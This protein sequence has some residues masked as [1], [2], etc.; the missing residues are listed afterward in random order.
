MELLARFGTIEQKEMW[1]GPLLRGEIRSCFG[2]T[3]PA[4]GS[5]DATNVCTAITKSSTSYIINGRKWWTSGASDPH[6][7]LIV[8]LGR[9]P[10]MSSRHNSHTILLVPMDAD[11]VKV[12]RNLKVFGYDDAPHGHAEISFT[13][14]TVPHSSLLYKEGKGFFCAQS[15][16]GGGRLHHCMRAIGA[17][18]RALAL[19]LSQAKTRVLGGTPLIKKDMFL[20]NI[21]QSRCDISAARAL[22]LA[23]CN[24]VDNNEKDKIREAVAIAKI[25]VPNLVHKVLDRAIQAHGG[26]G[27]S[28]DTVLAQLYAHMRS[29]RLADGPDEVH[30]LNLGKMEVRRARL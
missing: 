26:K 15:R 30:L 14:V 10:T 28:Q 27:V 18:E 6:C 7:K 17:A 16:L 25:S 5:S 19:S 21:A 3:E 1:L 20:S 13:N 4:V 29:L 2:M 8:L 12:I 22:V 23:A 24:A 9:G 11:G